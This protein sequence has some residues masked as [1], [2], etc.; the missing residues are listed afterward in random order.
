MTNH[1]GAYAEDLVQEVAGDDLLDGPGGHESSMVEDG[2]PVARGGSE[3][4]VVEHHQHGEAAVAEVAQQ[5]DLVTDVKVV[6][7]FVQDQHL[8]LLDQGAGDPDPLP[9][10]TGEAEDP[11]ICQIQDVHLR[12]GLSTQGKLA[13]GEGGPTGPVGG[14]DREPRPR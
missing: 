9:F 1:S 12:H 2:E 4:Q 7:G 6:R 11:P 10:T 3:V 8:W 14:F 13:A 5:L